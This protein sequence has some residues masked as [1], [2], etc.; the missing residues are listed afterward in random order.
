MNTIAKSSPVI[1]YRLREKYLYEI[2]KKQ[3]IR[4]GRRLCS[5][6]ESNGMERGY[7]KTVHLKWQPHRKERKLDAGPLIILEAGPLNFS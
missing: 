1:I 4:S 3:S 7:L 5:S 2:V 6:K